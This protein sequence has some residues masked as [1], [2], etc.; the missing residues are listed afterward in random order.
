[1]F[2]DFS[3]DAHL[4]VLY[5]FLVNLMQNIKIVFSS[6][7]LVK[8]LIPISKLDQ[9]KPLWV[10]LLKKFKFVCLR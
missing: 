9:N 8:R 3:G 5:S 6:Q 1:M 7:N 2:V 4:F 10:H